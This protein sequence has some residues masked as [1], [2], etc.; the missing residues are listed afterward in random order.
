MLFFSFEKEH[1]PPCQYRIEGSIKKS[2]LQDGFAN[3]GCAGQVLSKCC[4]KRR[5]CIH[6][7]DL[8][9]FFNQHDCDGEAGPAT[10]IDDAAT[11]RQC[12]RPPPHFLHANRI[13][14]IGTTTVATPREPFRRN[15]FVSI[16]LIHHQLT[17]SKLG[18][19]RHHFIARRAAVAP[20]SIPHSEPSPD[21]GELY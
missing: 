1:Q 14:S 12:F 20:P 2:R 4:D 13:R 5:R 11:W 17:V 19:P 6:P 3:N 16:G 10:E 21:V 7:E 9:S 18:S 15:R 8:K